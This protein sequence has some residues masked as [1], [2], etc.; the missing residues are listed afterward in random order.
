MAAVRKFDPEVVETAYPQAIDVPVAPHT[1]TATDSSL[2]QREP[3]TPNTDAHTN[4]SPHASDTQKVAAEMEPAAAL[5][6]NRGYDLEAQHQAL[7]LILDPHDLLYQPPEDEVLIGRQFYEAKETHTESTTTSE[8]PTGAE[9][10]LNAQDPE[11]I[12]ETDRDELV[13]AIHE[14][15]LE[16]A[17]E[18]RLY[19]EQYA[20][21]LAREAREFE[22]HA[23]RDEES[24]RETGHHED[25]EQDATCTQ[26][27]P[28]ELTREPFEHREP[29][30]EERDHKQDEGRKKHEPEEAENTAPTSDDEALVREEPEG[31]W[32]THFQFEQTQ[33]ATD[34]RGTRSALHEPHRCHRMLEDGQRCLRRPHPGAPFCLAHMR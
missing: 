31:A 23:E 1:Q 16:E 18:E 11:A 12:H 5:L 9:T 24:E 21:E 19:E 33:D 27:E 7:E 13:A 14:E 17:R 3:Q 29:H 25:N 4:A 32:L 22:K 2:T 20:E 30:A 10:E 28:Q 6:E 34:M 15:D 8:P 26:D